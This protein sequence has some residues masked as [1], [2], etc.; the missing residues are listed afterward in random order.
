MAQ[1][2]AQDATVERF[3]VAVPRHRD[4]GAGARSDDLPSPSD[5]RR[6]AVG[7]ARFVRK[8]TAAAVELLDPGDALPT[9]QARRGDLYRPPPPPGPPPR[10]PRP[11]PPSA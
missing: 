4:L 3:E 11:T 10:A 1:R 7:V 6:V 8:A 5:V 9:W 2:P